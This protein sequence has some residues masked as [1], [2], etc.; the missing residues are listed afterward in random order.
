[1]VDLDDRL[2]PPHPGPPHPNPPHPSAG[3]GAGATQPAPA[4]PHGS[5][6][7][8]RDFWFRPDATA[9]Q[10]NPAPPQPNSAAPADPSTPPMWQPPTPAPPLDTP[11]Q[12]HT[13]E[14]TEAARRAA[15]E[16]WQ[17]ALAA[18][19]PAPTPTPPNPATAQADPASPHHVAAQLPNPAAA[20]PHPPA[21]NDSPPQRPNSAAAGEVNAAGAQSSRAAQGTPATRQPN[22][23]GLQATPVAQQTPVAA[24]PST[25]AALPTDPA[26]QRIGPV[27]Q[28]TNPVA[29]RGIPVERQA[30]SAGMSAEAGA[31]VEGGVGRSGEVVARLLEAVRVSEGVGEG[32]S[33]GSELWQPAPAGSPTDAVPL[34]GGQG[35][36]VRAAVPS[37]LVLGGSGSS[38]ATTTALGLAAAA[39]V[40][41][42]GEIWPVVVDATLGGGDV[43]L[44]GCDAAAPVSTLQKW[45]GT[46]YPGLASSVG[47]CSGQTS[48]GVRVLAR[49]PDPLPRRESLVSV[50]RHLE[51]AGLLGI[52]DA[53]APVT[54]RLAAP[55]LSDPRV[56]LVITVAARPDAI[57]R[58]Q[59]ALAWLDESF[60]EFVVGD[61]VIVLTEQVPG[62]AAAVMDHV[63]TH[64]GSWVR[65]VL[66]IPFDI[67]LA[68]GGTISW[69]RLAAETRDAYLALL[70]ALR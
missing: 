35:R 69:H 61:A 13:A 10:P 48:T 58:L 62:S 28:Q 64:L 11:H 6:T 14:Q 51:T 50:A 37:V 46:A 66:Q 60:S 56:G 33:G 26:A 41:S 8:H 59:P 4:E 57:N 43:A 7:P 55:L 68:S 49:T 2:R 40:D 24:R 47:A 1:M 70:G 27:A 54:S 29:R 23:G 15:A 53:G 12:P 36:L 19:R 9:Q 65:D 45:L 42:D 34:R 3:A 21:Q 32:D 31:E 44:R 38:G 63:R 22:P 17:A 52:F 16:A 67:H 18:Q 5:P 20:Q 39:A 25:P 30:D